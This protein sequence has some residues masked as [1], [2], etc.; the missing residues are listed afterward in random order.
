MKTI[1]GDWKMKKHCIFAVLLVVI[2]SFCG[3]IFDMTSS[4]IGGVE[5]TEPAGPSEPVGPTE[6]SG[7]V[8][9]TEPVE[10]VEPIIASMSAAAG[11]YGIS[12]ENYPR[13]DG[14]TS[15]LPLVQGI[16]DAMYETGVLYPETASKTVPSYE[17]LINGE[18]DLILV[19][20]ASSAVL[21]LARE[22]NVTLEFF[23]IA[24]EAL[25]FITPVENNA[26]NITMEQVRDIYINYGIK[27]WKEL[28]GPS[29]K[30]IP[31]CRNSDSGSQAAMDGTVLGDE[32]MHPE[33]QKNYKAMNMDDMLFQVA[34]Y[35]TE[36]SGFL[37]IRRDKNSFALGYT[38]YTWYL[39][40]A[41]MT[42]IDSRLR[43]LSFEG[44][45]PDHDS[46]MD[47]SYPLAIKYYAVIR[48]DLPEGH[49][50]RGIIDFLQSENGANSIRRE[51]LIPIAPG[52]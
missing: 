26:G 20:Y 4:T 10:P 46:I 14:S 6:P 49:S 45:A 21:D 27:N 23:P 52:L 5:P 50:A 2:I 39:G 51:G 38:L 7:P 18:A 28:G 32:E 43:I 12:D 33:I 8:E 37:P 15:T 30:L 25:I 9:P 34:F 3:C 36:K 24:L 13:I 31:I 41:D 44:I 19:P 29:R 35:H 22:S 47:G 17:L 42:G 11:N 40:E 1:G 48:S 16:H